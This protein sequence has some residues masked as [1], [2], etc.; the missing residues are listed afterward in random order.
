VTDSAS[1]LLDGG[2]VDDG[3]A[4]VHTMLVMMMMKMMLESL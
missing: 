1:V 4:V 3:E 2:W